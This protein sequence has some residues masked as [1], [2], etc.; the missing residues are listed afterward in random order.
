MTAALS[1]EM[2]GLGWNWI[3]AYVVAHGHFDPVVVDSQWSLVDLYETYYSLQL[4]D[5][6]A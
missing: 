5:L 2:E 1:R 3:K 6:L 4:A